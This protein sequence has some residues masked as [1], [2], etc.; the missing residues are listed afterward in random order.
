MAV[1]WEQLYAERCD[2]LNASGIREILKVSG[3]P[4]FISLAGG[5]PAPELFPV[6]E[7]RRA[8]EL[9]LE[10]A[11][12]QAL[13][14]GATE[15]YEPLRAFISARLARLWNIRSTPDEVL[16]TSGSQQA[17]DLVGRLFINPGDAVVVE[18]PSYVAA[19]QA[20]ISYQARFLVAPT[21]DDGVRT[22]ALEELLA[23]EVV[24][25]IYLVPTFQNPSG[26]TL[27]LPRRQHLLELSER[28]G[29]PIIEDDPYSELR[30]E[31]QAI[32]PLKALDPDGRVIYLGTFSKILNPGMR[33]GWI[34]AA[35]PVLDKLVLAK[36]P[37][38]LHTGMFQ[39]MVTFE[40]VR[41]GFLE[42]H[43]QR[44]IPVY[45]ERRDALLAALARHFP[46]GEVTWTRPQGGLFVW[47]T[48]PPDCHALD[49]FR[50]AAQED[51]SFVPGE[52]FHPRG[53]V[54]N[55]LRLNFSNAAPH[56]LEDAVARLARAFSKVERGK[57][58]TRQYHEPLAI[59]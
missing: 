52:S 31:G 37:A 3:G 15:G 43:V 50:E 54:H 57:R 44:L 35:R 28:Y 18:D 32:P 8:C 29:V 59:I 34:V 56:K 17:L 7:V 11:P 58:R 27:S 20:F 53:D 23:R 39:Q 12:E 36:Q 16:I 49:F 33:L 10:N 22:D 47:A 1:Q 46:G 41:A 40:V 38:D 19:L 13:Q 14:Y 48:L 51:V 2:G 6:D 4:N 26:R 5:L 55:T 24:K 42:P 21:D 30:Y 45:R 25:F 9:V